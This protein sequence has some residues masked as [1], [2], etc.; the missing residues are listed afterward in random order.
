MRTARTTGRESQ[1]G[2]EAPP[3]LILTAVIVECAITVAMCVL[4]LPIG[5]ALAAANCVMASVTQGV[6][7]KLLIASAVSGTCI[8]LVLLLTLFRASTTVDVGPASPL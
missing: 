8:A 4:A 3:A 5:I 1:P 7:R 2:D 6:I